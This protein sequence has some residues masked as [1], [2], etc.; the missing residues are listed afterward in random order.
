[1][2]YEFHVGDYVETKDGRVGYLTGISQY[3]S[4]SC[5][6]WGINLIGK[7]RKGETETGFNIY[8][9]QSSI[10]R[11]FKRIG[12]IGECDSVKI[13]QSKEIERLPDDIRA[14]FV[15]N[16]KHCHVK[17]YDGDNKWSYMC[18]PKEFI[19]KINELVDAVNELREDKKKC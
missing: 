16:D 17:Q 14:T 18:Y 9:A 3:W 7:V 11:Y 6:C 2:K 10:W 15:I 4:K 12:N 5:N 13:E 1:M 8:I 19:D